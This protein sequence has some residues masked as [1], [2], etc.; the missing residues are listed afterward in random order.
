MRRGDIGH[1]VLAALLS[2]AGV[3]GE[4]AGGF[5]DLQAKYLAA[6]ARIRATYD[7]VVS[8]AAAS[9]AHALAEQGAAYQRQGN[10]DPYLAFKQ[11]GDKLAQQGLAACLG[12]TNSFK[13]LAE[14]QKSHAD[15]LLEAAR[16]WDL[17][18][19]SLNRAYLAQLKTRVAALTQS[20]RIDEAVAARKEIEV[21]QGRL[22]AVPSAMPAAPAAPAAGVRGAAPAA[23]WHSPPIPPPAPGGWIVL[24]DGEKLRGCDLDPELVQSGAIRVE[25]GALRL[26]SDR[27]IGIVFN[28]SGRDVAIRARV[29]R[30]S[31]S[32]G[33][34][35]RKG[36]DV[37][38]SGGFSSRDQCGIQRIDERTG[39]YVTLKGTLAPGAYDDYFD[40]EVSARG[41]TVAVKADGKTLVETEDEV[42]REGR[43]RIGV[44]DGASSFKKVEVKILDS[45]R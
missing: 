27:P 19:Q 14:L 31:G 22:A 23:P 8:N 9:Y 35:V 32:V 6:Q 18:D 11:E 4:A 7:A 37:S 1:L 5:D 38:Y 30:E 16:S 29:K 44:R 39:R 25:G 34:R 33:L 26:Q 28:A 12:Q 24:F 41:R 42:A 2:A 3:R 21:A 17:A 45:P 13:P 43:F 10:L 15:Y 36:P 20:N 40:L